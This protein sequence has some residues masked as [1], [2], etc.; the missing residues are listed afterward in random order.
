MPALVSPVTG[1]W[2]A[3]KE[4]EWRKIDITGE[5]ENPFTAQQ[6]VYPWN[7]AWLEASLSWVLTNPQFQLMDAWLDSLQ[8]IA[9]VFPFG[10]PVNIAPIHPGATAPSVNGANQSGFTLNVSG[11]GYQSVGD[12]ISIPGP[13]SYNGLNYSAGSRLY[14]VT[15]VSSGV[16]GVW[17]NLREPPTSGQLISIATCQG[18]FR[19]K[20]NDRQ[21]MQRTDKSWSLTYEVREAI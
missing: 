8:G 14:R 5:N 1:L 11:G 4:I 20:K 9:G 3:P 16:L 21:A 18:T 2:I 10:D 17:P 6:Q 15:S 19:L 13:S 12:F 7:T